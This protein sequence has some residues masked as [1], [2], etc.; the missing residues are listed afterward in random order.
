MMGRAIGIGILLI[1]V[2]SGCATTAPSQALPS[3][4]GVSVYQTRTDYAVRRLEVSVTNATGGPVQI[5]RVQFRSEQFTEPVDWQ[6]D[7]TTVVDG[8]TVDLPVLLAEPNCAATSL[9][10]TVEFDYVL[11]SG[12]SGTAVT[13][14]DDRIDRLPALHAEDCMVHAVAEV[15]ALSATTAPRSSVRD[16]RAVVEL[17]LT[18]EPTGAEGAIVVDSLAGT[19]LFVP[20]DP[21]TGT[22]VT[23]YRIDRPIL[24]TDP[25]SVITLTLT[26][27]RCDPHAV[28]EDKRGTF[29]PLTVEA[30][31]QS[32]RIYIGVSDAVR[33]A[34]YTFIGE[35]CGTG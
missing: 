21:A 1:A 29:M 2:V 20:V 5:T 34:L 32:G 8:A 6:K 10:P 7:S 22:P 4:L 25:A 13:I 9:V 11:A 15:V 33:G 35:A 30:G 19:T 14:A 27:A 17:D 31:G 12:V 26:P 28:A 16:G 18:A 3:G 24:G 23:S